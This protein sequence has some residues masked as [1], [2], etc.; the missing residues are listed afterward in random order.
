VRKAGDRASL[1]TKQ[2]LAFSRRQVLNPK[3]L[4]LNAVV[5][6][7]DMMLRRLIGEHIDLV[8][9]LAPDLGRVK[10]DPGQIGQ[11]LLN[12]AVNARD[13]MSDGGRLTFETSNVELSADYAR[14][15]PGMAAGH[16]VLLAVSDTGCGMTT[17]IRERIFD[18][19]FTTKETG[20]GTGLG[21]STVYGIVKQSG[22]GVGV[23]SEPGTGT[24]FKVYLPRIGA[25]VERAER[26]PE[27]LPAVGARRGG[28]LLLVEDDTALRSFTRDLLVHEGYEVLEAADRPSA[29]AAAESHPGI[30]LLLTDVVMP[31]MNGRDLARRL[32]A[33]RP[34]L[35]TVY[36]SGYPANAIAHHGALEEGLAFV[37]KPFTPQALIGRLQAVL[38]GAAG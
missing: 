31:Q 24:A 26:V 5:A 13:A 33:S 6:D 20:K 30:Q 11:V 25:P 38:A 8:T 29:L 28:T 35:K 9:H 21:L 2:L 1:L 17:A 19:F 14:T 32:E 22:G 4:E 27:P 10:V 16:Y 15:H 12:L 7:M 34:G 23:Y 3:V 18:P 36:M 37:E